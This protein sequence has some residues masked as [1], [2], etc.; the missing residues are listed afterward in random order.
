[1][2]KLTLNQNKPSPYAAILNGGAKLNQQN[3]IFASIPSRLQ[4]RLTAE[5]AATVLGFS[6]HQIPILISAKLLTPLAN[7]VPNATKYFAASV[8]EQL[9]NN[10][11]WLNDATQA[12]YD[13]WSGKTQRKK[14]NAI[15]V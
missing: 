14:Q 13:Y 9:A 11:N 5:Q 2:E 8:I 12:I 4:A 3:Q 15:S 6:D 10:I 1:M 7:P